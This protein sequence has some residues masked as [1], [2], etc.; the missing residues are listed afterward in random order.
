MARTR[1]SPLNLGIS[2]SWHQLDGRQKN[3]ELLHDVKAK[4]WSSSLTLRLL[5]S[6]VRSTRC[7][8][9]RVLDGV[10]I[11]IYFAAGYGAGDGAEGL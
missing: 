2:T 1:S 3:S 8:N 4:K 5:A 7:A 6:I 11:G 9:E 10:F